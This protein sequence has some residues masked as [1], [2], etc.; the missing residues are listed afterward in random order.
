MCPLPAAAPV[1]QLCGGGD[2]STPERT[3]RSREMPP[4]AESHSVGG[5]GPASGGSGGK[6]GGSLGRARGKHDKDVL[7]RQKPGGGKPGGKQGGKQ[8]GG[9]PGG[10]AGGKPGGKPGGKEGGGKA[11]GLLGARRFN[12]SAERAAE[13]QLLRASGNASASRLRAK[14]ARAWLL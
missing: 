2:G 11:G 7:P 14:S 5:G 13:R 3:W 12:A 9:K 4:G 8:G 10:K 1:R 6:Q